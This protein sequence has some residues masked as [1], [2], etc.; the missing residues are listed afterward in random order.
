MVVSQTMENLDNQVLTTETRASLGMSSCNSYDFLGTLQSGL[1]SYNFVS[2]LLR[3]KVL[4]G[5]EF[6]L[7]KLGSH[8]PTCQTGG[9]RQKYCHLQHSHRMAK[10]SILKEKWVPITKKKVGV[11]DK[12]QWMSVIPILR[13]EPTKEQ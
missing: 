13:T 1:S 9:M 4:V 6:I 3:L 5:G 11:G 10:S 2:P 8:N 7:Y 12:N